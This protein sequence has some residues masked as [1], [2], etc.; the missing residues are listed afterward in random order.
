SS[1]RRHTRFSRDWSSDVC[2]F[3]LRYMKRLTHFVTIVFLGLIGSQSIQAQTLDPV[4][5]N[6]AVVGINKLD[7]RAT[8]FP[9][10]SLELAKADRSEER[11]VGK[12]YRYK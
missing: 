2:S 4:I 9:Y 3:D 12:K 8:F 11:R 1:R 5:E 7:A 6:P 10:N